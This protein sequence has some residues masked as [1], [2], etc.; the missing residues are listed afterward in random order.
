MTN[1]IFCED[2]AVTMRRM[3]P[4]SVDLV[5]TSPP[6]NTARSC[7]DRYHSGRYDVYSEGLSE[8]EYGRWICGLF[9]DGID[10]ILKRN[11]CVLWNFSWSS[12]SPMSFFR[13]VSRIDEE[14]PFTVADVI[15]WKKN[16]ALPNNMSPNKLTR[17]TEPV[18]VLCR[19]SEFGTFHANKRVIS[20]RKGGQCNY[21]NLFAFIEARNN[22]GPCDLNRATFS[23]DLV[24]RL[25]EMYAPEGAVVYDPFMGTGTTAVGCRRFGATYVGSEISEA[26]CK[27]AEERLGRLSQD[28][29]GEWRAR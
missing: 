15:V 22:D 13:V 23:S 7:Q 5:L 3:P 16:S 4:Q 8:D 21:E 28:M 10:K 17:I 25:L 2:C 9:S 29:F 27:Y 14:T 19:K 24:V 6:Y 18:L 1:Q 12:E 26:Q 20:R 11:G